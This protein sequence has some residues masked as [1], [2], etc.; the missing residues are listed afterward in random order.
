MKVRR[1]KNS[2]V[3]AFIGLAYLGEDTAGNSTTLAKLCEANKAPVN[4]GADGAEAR[5][6]WG[7]MPRPLRR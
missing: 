6:C 2:A 7:R 1:M 5:S 4:D 3:K